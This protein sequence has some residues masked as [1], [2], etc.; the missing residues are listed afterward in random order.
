MHCKQRM[1]NTDGLDGPSGVHDKNIHHFEIE[2]EP[3]R[4]SVCC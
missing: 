1:H 2:V 4:Y 3:N